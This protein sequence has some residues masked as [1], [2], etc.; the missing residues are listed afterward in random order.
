MALSVWIDNN[1]LT[2]AGG[3]AG[4]IHSWGAWAV[5]L[6]V[7]MALLALIFGESRARREL[8]RISRECAGRPVSWRLLAGHAAAMGCFVALSARL[9]AGHS[10]SNLSAALW[11]A[12]GM[13]AIA[14]AACA[15]VPPAAW[16]ALARSSGD[17]LIYAIAAAVIAC[18]LGQSFWRLWMPLSR[19]TFA[20][21]QWMLAPLLPT[22][23][24]NP[25]AFLI[26]TPRF[27]VQIAPECSGYEGM[28]LVLAFSAAWLWF[29]R[30]EWRF[31]NALLL[32]PAGVAA[33]FLLNSAR[34]AA[35]ILIGNA[36][37]ERVAMGGFHS[38]AGWLA[39]NGVALGVCVGAR[40]I[41]WLARA[42]QPAAVGA[43]SAARTARADGTAAYLLPFLA[44][45]AAAMLARA[46]SGDFEW[47]YP[48][49]V[50]AA[51]A[52]LWYFRD[53]YRKLDWRASWQAFAAGALV[54]ALW[55]ALEPLAAGH[56]DPAPAAWLHAST[57]ARI[58]WA[59]FRIA[60]AIVTVPLAEE[61]AFR[62]YLLRRL[63]SGNFEAVS[64]RAFAW[65]PLIVSSAAF[66]LMH[67]ERWLAGTLAGAMYALVQMRRGRI[68]EA[69]AAH[70]VTNALLAACVL[71]TGNWALW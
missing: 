49:R 41:P 6:A 29:L 42:P 26:G 11:L 14:L 7:A 23:H 38:Q 61:L 39:F 10:A 17:A 64:W 12:F 40:R 54:F 27:E 65:M 24:A 15:L 21:V 63:A 4:I 53:T 2:G 8:S 31:P 13:A 62:G 66:G 51:A 32:V 59:A 48:L 19:W 45:L 55:M 46:M 9:Y 25:A 20:L 1:A 44:V 60:G 3:L 56:P 68:G 5:R 52:A 22:L 36:G 28:G 47:A 18:V 37:A 43:E 70:A 57:G 30:R 33:M 67:G 34:I 16:L 71:A 69:V 50:A 58:A 35:L